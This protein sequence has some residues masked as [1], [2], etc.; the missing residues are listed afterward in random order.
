MLGGLWPI[1]PEETAIAQFIALVAGTLG[2]G[3]AILM[4]L[5]VGRSYKRP[6]R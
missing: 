4:R 2:I 1:P 6:A 5:G 3:A